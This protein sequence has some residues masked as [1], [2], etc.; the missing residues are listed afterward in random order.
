MTIAIDMVATNLESG[1]KTY[2][3]NFCEN[4]N[5]Y[6]T[7]EKI[8][9]FI[10]KDYLDKID[11]NQNSN[12]TYLVKP[13]L[14]SNIFFRIFWMQFILPFELKILK[15]DKL[16][17]PMN[18]AP[19]CLKLFNIKLVL[20]L[21]SNLPWIHF[22]KMP[23]NVIRNY[24]TK[25][26]MKFSINVC[27]KLIV[28]S[29]FAKDEIIRLLKIK[30]E[31]VISIYL[32]IDKKYLDLSNKKFYLENF[33]YKNYILSVI[34]CAKYHNIIKLLEGF[35]LLK[36]ENKIKLRFIFVLQVLDQKYFDEIKNFVSNNFDKSE[37][38]FFHNLNRKYL[39]NLYGNANFYIFSSSCEVFGLTS[40]EAMSQGCPVLISEKSALPEINLN[41]VDYFNP[42]KEY[43]IK[44]RMS[45]MLNDNKH[46]QDIIKK[47][48]I[49]CKKFSWS[50]TVS[51]T[52]DVLSN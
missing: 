46:K 41:A 30:K 16:F 2:N 33:D 11:I 48:N 10:T 34:S 38:I 50:K 35:K 43:E 7:K 49:H 47:G 14:L 19:L 3:I 39:V 24:L 27:D 31:K 6:K 8:F 23:G 45:K 9:V 37:I 36:K 28:A 13:S 29:N 5:I 25:L 1:T 21:H 42:D 17:S 51:E 18:I 22:S 26:L 32:G 40:L 52:M 4:L 12:I 44:D 20:A 15:V